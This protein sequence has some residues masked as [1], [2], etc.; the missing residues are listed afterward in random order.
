[1]PF[2]PFAPVDPSDSF[3]DELGR[4]LCRTGGTFGTFGTD[5]R[6]M[7]DGGTA[8]GRV[9]RLRR[10]A[11]VAGGAATLTLVGV[12][13]L[14]AGGAPGSIG[15]H[16]E[17]GSA[18]QGGVKPLADA[19]GERIDAQ[20]MIKLLTSALPPGTTT[21]EDGRGIGGDGADG[22]P[23]APYAGVVFNDG[24][25][26]G[27]VTVSLNRVAAGQREGGTKCPDRT[28][29]PFD[30]CDT[31]VLADGSV[32]ILLKGYEYPDR[33]VDTKNWRAT[34]TTRDGRVVDAQEWNSPAEKGAPD[35][36]IDPPLT[37]AQL[38]A[39]VNAEIWQPVFDA[40]PP[41]K[42]PETAPG[43]AG[44][45]SSP[46]G[47]EIAATLK[48]LVP[49]GLHLGDADATDGFAHATV[50]DGHGKSLVE[51][52]VDHWSLK[53][54]QPAARGGARRRRDP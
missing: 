10:R 34:L 1:M 29:V 27:L 11:A 13:G 49:A 24:K 32:L 4:A 28:Y 45:K 5:N 18:A 37:P 35:T 31:T 53:G 50:D 38:T 20:R 54:S 25:G 6:A 12:G 8:R 48:R 15:H 47:A 41:L 17:E 43:S 33:R 36:R 3:E 51:V 23:G 42:V 22:P 52:T 40:L 26:T 14:M 21:G 46:S 9:M 7:V 39:L 44:A 30:A 2:D 16:V 19:S